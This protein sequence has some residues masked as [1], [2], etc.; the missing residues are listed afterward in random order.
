ML[1][2][3]R[4]QNL[5][6]TRNDTTSESKTT[7]KNTGKLY[8]GT[9][10][11]LKIYKL[12]FPNGYRIGKRLATS[13]IN[14]SYLFRA[15]VSVAFELGKTRLVEAILNH[16]IVLSS[17][18]PSI[19]YYEGQIPGIYYPILPI[20]G[21]RKPR[22]IIL[23]LFAAKEILDTKH[24][25][26]KPLSVT[27]AD[28]PR[29]KDMPCLLRLSEKHDSRSLEK[30][31]K[32]TIVITGSS[33]NYSQVNNYTSIET[34]FIYRNRIDRITSAADPYTFYYYRSTGPFY[35]LACIDTIYLEYF[36]HAL[37]VLGEKG[38]GSSRSNGYGKFIVKKSDQ[39][40]DE[41]LNITSLENGGRRVLFLGDYLV[42]KQLPAMIVEQGTFLA[43]YQIYGHLGHRL[44]TGFIHVRSLLA[45][46]TILEL[47]GNSRLEPEIEYDTR[48]R[49]I[50]IYNPLVIGGE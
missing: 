7:M 28:D 21:L 3:D 37:K 32:R 10:C 16:K 11:N 1:A 34:S 20:S 19:T 24:G 50:F 15:V 43:L 46:G 26:N 47:R 13:I 22:S 27:I 38:I 41:N 48:T 30:C 25:L 6:T 35:F 18:L 40:F 45:P 17:L 42:T 2:Q 23:D 14:S 4:Q 33:T 49:Q 39:V 5:E 44:N 8:G 36:E 31:K 9:M 12:Y 29:D